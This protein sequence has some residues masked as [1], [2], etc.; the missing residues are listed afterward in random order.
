MATRTTSVARQTR[1]AGVSLPVFSLP[2]DEGIGDFG[3]SAYDFIDWLRAAGQRYWQVLPLTLPDSVGSP[4]ASPSG[5]AGNWMFINSQELQREGLLPKKYPYLRDRAA[6]VHYRVV[7]ARKWAMIRASFDWF[8][9]HGSPALRDEWRRFTHS[10]R[11]WL[12]DFVLYQTIKD[13]HRTRPWWTWEKRWQTPASAR[14]HTDARMFR[15][16]QLHAYAQWLF[17]RQWNRL[18][19]YGHRRGLQYIGDLPFYVQLDSVEVWSHPELFELDARRRPREVAG[20]PPDG[21][22]PRGQRWGN[23]V[24]RWS[25]HRRTH[26]QWYLD[27]FDVLT[28]RY[29]LIR[30]D[31]FFGLN[32]TFHIPAKDPDARHGRWVKTPGRLFLTALRK[33]FRTLPIIAEDLSPKEPS[34]ERLRKP[35]HL[36]AVRALPF[37]WTD[38][39]Q[40]M[41]HPKYVLR[42][43]CYY[44][45][46]H[47][48]NT[49]MGWWRD[50]A[51]VAERKAIRG[52]MKKSRPRHWELMALV[53][54]SRAT[55]AMTTIQDLLGSGTESRINRPGTKRGNWTWRMPAHRLDKTLAARL[56][57][58]TKRY[59]RAP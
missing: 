14:R 28:R 11:S 10:E 16:M 22:S 4:Y 40:N 27:R 51:S 33:R 26:W 29:D 8:L 13:R 1:Q 31:H 32:A 7:A 3:P 50:D 53:Y 17:S 47:D 42:E 48:T 20:V 25:A 24:Y 34:D 56:R 5:M 23:P 52:W 2:G 45:S 57:G 35:F 30:F 21:F 55:L 38:I 58:M 18:R 37:G 49:L 12:D 54:S 9:N 59:H 6:R 36:P 39:P 41:H 44:T 46:I 19:N 15:R 43:A